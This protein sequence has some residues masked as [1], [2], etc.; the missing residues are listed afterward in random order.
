MTFAVDWALETNY[1]STWALKTNYLSIWALKTNY[2]STFETSYIIIAGL[3]RRTSK[4][5]NSADYTI[6]S[7]SGQSPF[8]FRLCRSSGGGLRVSCLNQFEGEG[9]NRPKAARDRRDGGA[10]LRFARRPRTGEGGGEL[11]VYAELLL[12]TTR[13][14]WCTRVRFIKHVLYVT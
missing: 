4:T 3:V 1:I 2:L 6:G 12:Q 13:T 11:T 10:R 5:Q 14:A 9:R 7:Q 8:R